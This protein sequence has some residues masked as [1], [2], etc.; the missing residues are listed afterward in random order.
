LNFKL[1]ISEEQFDQE[2]TALFEHIND[3]KMQMLQIESS[4]KEDKNHNNDISLISTMI[5]HPN[6]NEK[7]DYSDD[8]SPDYQLN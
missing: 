5:S 8:V 2:Y 1:N 7:T 3:Q 4:E 6:A